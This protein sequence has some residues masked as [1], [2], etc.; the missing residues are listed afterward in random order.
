M[1]TGAFR[2]LPTVGVA[3]LATVLLTG[4]GRRVDDEWT[5]QRP[6]VYPA[7]GS[8]FYQ[9][10][11]VAGATVMF[12]SADSGAKPGSGLVAIG[13]TDSAGM[14][15]MKTYKEYE[16]VVA[17]AHRVSVTKMDY[18]PATRPAGVDPN[19]DIPPIATSVLPEKYKDFGT[20]GLTVNV[21]SKG[22]DQIRL[23][24]E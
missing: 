6:Q 18:V 8:V 21:T 15:R 1:T 2:R 5:R 16:G 14:F 13:H 3:C 9:N 17:G 4:C 23:D 7:T 20:S 22:A 19:V 24:L 12:E 11:P 10:K